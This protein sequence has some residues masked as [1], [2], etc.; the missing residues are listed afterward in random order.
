MI[1]IPVSRRNKMSSNHLTDLLPMT[2]GVEEPKW[3][4]PN[5]LGNAEYL[6]ASRTPRKSANPCPQMTA[7]EPPRSVLQFGMQYFLLYVPLVLFS[8]S[9]VS[10][11]KK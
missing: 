11:S 5:D 8:G 3:K 7:P 1:T 4:F 6:V 10:K 9:L 2:Q